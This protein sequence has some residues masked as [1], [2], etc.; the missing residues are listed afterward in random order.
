MMISIN[1][2]FLREY[3]MMTKFV[4]NRCVKAFIYV[5]LFAI[6]F[7]ATNAQASTVFSDIG[8]KMIEVFNNVR[9]IIFIVGGFGLVGLGFAAI[10][11]KIKWTWLAAL[12]AGL[13]IVALAGKVVD[14]VVDSG[15]SDSDT[16]SHEWADVGSTWDEGN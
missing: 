3:I 1:Y 13:A 10:F 9:S 11:G 4:S 2:D 15:A 7:M 8:G 16:V 5:A 14:Y 6:S 12:A